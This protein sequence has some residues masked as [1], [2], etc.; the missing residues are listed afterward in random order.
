MDRKG[1]KA[2]IA[3]IAFLIGGITLAHYVTEWNVHY[4]HIFYQ[5]LYFLPIILAGFWCGLRGALAAALSITVL[6][7][8]FTVIHWNGFSPDDLNS[9]LEMVLYNVVALILGTLRDRETVVQRRL[10]ESEGLASMGKMVSCLAHDLKTPLIAIGGFARLVQKSLENHDFSFGKKLDIIVRETTRLKRMVEEMLDFSRPLELS[11][12]QGDTKEIVNQC[13][14]ILSD[15]PHAKKVKFQNVCLQDPTL[16]SFDSDR[17]KQALINLLT[18]AVEASPEDGTVA[19]YCYQKKRR[20]IIEIKDEGSGVPTSKREEIF[21]PFFTTKEGGTGLGLP[22]AKKI[23]EAHHGFLE[24]IENSG[25]GVTFR[26]TI[27]FS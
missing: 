15:L 25:K 5:G 27:P 10:R 13:L 21:C 24:V 8:P 17:M 23:I 19:V 9:V 1:T 2:R 16:M 14:A 6:Y 26:V 12:T 11:L 3:F 22:I 20:L 4:Y 18:N 7:L